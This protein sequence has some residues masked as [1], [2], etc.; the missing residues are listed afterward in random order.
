MT[1]S[2]VE[3][4]FDIA[5]ND[6][7]FDAPG[8]LSCCFGVETNDCCF[9]VEEGQM[10]Y[11]SVAYGN[12]CT[13]VKRCCIESCSKREDETEVITFKWHKASGAELDD[14]G[15]IKMDGEWEL[16]DVV[17]EL[18]FSDG[19]PLLGAT[20]DPVIALKIDG[21]TPMDET[22][23]HKYLSR[24]GIAGGVA[25][26]KYRVTACGDFKNCDGFTKKV[27]FCVNLRVEECC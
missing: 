2:V 19:S 7:C 16:L 22:Y 12:C 15:Q 20:N 1:M 27:C 5:P 24:I 6:C 3:C 17:H 4:C 14:D 23:R 10:T 26:E 8:R 25:G 11:R 18:T 13:P 21:T 9:T